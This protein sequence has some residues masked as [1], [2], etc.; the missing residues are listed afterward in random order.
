[1]AKRRK[2]ALKDYE[3]K[4]VQAKSK[5]E[6]AEDKLARS[7]TRFLAARKKVNYYERVIDNFELEGTLGEPE[8]KPVKKPRNVEEDEAKAPPTKEEI[9]TVGKTLGLMEGIM[10][11]SLKGHAKPAKAAMKATINRDVQ[12]AVKAKK[13][14]KREKLALEAAERPW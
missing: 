7:M 3:S 4:L 12:Q 2:L 5:L 14:S 9:A 13:I 8:I 11:A 10:A 1:M 6:K